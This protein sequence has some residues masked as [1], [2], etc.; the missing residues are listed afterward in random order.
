MEWTKLGAKG[1]LF[2]SFIFLVLLS[3]LLTDFLYLDS[4]QRAL[5]RG[6][7]SNLAL[8]QSYENLTR[9]W[10]KRM[11]QAKLKASS[12]LFQEFPGERK[13]LQ[14]EAEGYADLLRKK[15][16]PHP[17]YRW[18]SFL[19]TPFPF[20]LQ[21]LI[22]FFLGDRLYLREEKNGYSSLIR[23]CAYPKHQRFWVRLFLFLLLIVLLSGLIYFFYFLVESAMRGGLKNDIAQSLPSLLE[24]DRPLSTKGLFWLLFSMRSLATI[25]LT[26]CFCFLFL[27]SKRILPALLILSLFMG[28]SFGILRGISLNSPLVFWRSFN[29]AWVFLF[30]NELPLNSRLVFGNQVIEAEFVALLFWVFFDLLLVGGLYGWSEKE[31]G[32]RKRW[33]CKKIEASENKNQKTQP[34]FLT[35]P[36]KN[37]KRCGK[38]SRRYTE[39]VR[40]LKTPFFLCFFL[41]LMFALG[42]QTIRYKH[43]ET[44]QEKAQNDLYAEYGGRLDL[45]KRAQLEAF[46]DAYQ[47]SQKETTQLHQKLQREKN[48]EEQE[49]IR[50]QIA[51]AQEE[52]LPI[53]E[54]YPVIKRYEEIQKIGGDY[55]VQVLPYKLLLGIEGASL[56][57]RDYLFGMMAL[58]FFLIIAF[59]P[60]FE[61]DQINYM[62]CLSGGR[63]KLI[64]RKLRTIVAVIFVV[65]C[66]LYGA[67]LVK[68][69]NNF[70]LPT[71]LL[72]LKNINPEMS[73]PISVGMAYGFQV[74][75]ACLI[76]YLISLV[77]LLTFFTGNRMVSLG[78]AA[79]VSLSPWLLY[80]AKKDGLS[81][82]SLLNGYALSNPGIA[83]AQMV[84]LIGLILYLRASLILS[85]REGSLRLRGLYD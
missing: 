31:E 62:R 44:S 20:F 1:W 7:S 74:V 16:Y 57:T 5:R 83:A 11:G 12:D 48:P 85:W 72:S 4:E 25:G 58:I 61:P 51:K 81:I 33:I 15:V 3:V 63:D 14:A 28:A 47:Q 35:N 59:E 22:A 17:N 65:Q 34:A 60:D 18:Q 36:T 23:S 41:V 24:L 68:I 84:I 32:R 10:K 29:P 80:L 56:Q 52:G 75:S 46:I 37:S 9:Q 82:F 67:R 66:L 45:S 71:L 21:I 70:P 64:R 42:Y 30:F 53:P 26:V 69:K 8:E 43:T 2:L 55:L 50:R 78:V 77:T 73:L 76:G 79:S 54:L 38:H 6:A 27:F 39:S 40:I 13:R 49:A 19:T